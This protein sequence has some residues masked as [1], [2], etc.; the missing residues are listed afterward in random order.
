MLPR[1]LFQ[2]LL[3]VLRKLGSSCL[4]GETK[5]VVTYHPAAV[6]RNPRLG[7]IVEHDIQMMS[8][9]IAGE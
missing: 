6:L 5:V 3:G 2:N 7:E 1:H 8:R 9:L 4:S